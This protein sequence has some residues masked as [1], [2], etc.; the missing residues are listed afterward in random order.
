ME[1]RNLKGRYGRVLSRGGPAK[2]K[3]NVATGFCKPRAKKVRWIPPLKLFRVGLCFLF[4]GIVYP[5]FIHAH[6]PHD[7]VDAFVVSPDYSQ[8]KTLF[9]ASKGSINVFLA[10]HD[11][12]FTWESSRSGMR[13]RLIHAIA[14]DPNWGNSGV[15]YVVGTAGLEKTSDQGQSWQHVY[16]H[17]DLR[18]IALGRDSANSSD[19]IFAS[20]FQ[21]LFRTDLRDQKKSI[22]LPIGQAKILALAVSPNFEQDKTIVVASD[23]SQLFFSRNAGS[24]WEAVAVQAPVHKITFSPQYST[25]RTLWL[26]SHG[27]GILRSKDGGMTIDSMAAKIVGP[28]VNDIAAAPN[29]PDPAHLLAATPQGGVYL[30]RDAGVTWELTGLEIEKNWQ[31]KENHFKTV[32]FSPSYPKDATLFCGTFEGMNI[33]RDGGQNWQECNINPTRMGRRVAISRTFAADHSLFAGGYGQGILIS[34]DGGGTWRNSFRRFKE[35]GAYSIA[36][37]PQY[38]KDSLFLVGVGSGIRR[39]PD[40]GLTWQII[41]LDHKSTGEPKDEFRLGSPIYHIEYSPEFARDHT[42]YAVCLKGDVFRSKDA[43]L[44]W[45]SIAQVSSQWTSRLRLSPN[46]ARDSTMFAGKKFLHRSVDGGQTFEQVLDKWMRDLFVAPDFETSGEVFCAILSSEGVMKS[47]DRGNTWSYSGAGLEGYEPLSMSFSA[48]YKNDGTI[49]LLTLGGGLFRST[50]RG[51]HWERAIPLGTPVDSASCM[52][53]SP[54]FSE[55]GMMLLGVYNGFLLTKDGGGT[56]RH[57]TNSEFYDISRSPWVRRGSDWQ[58][59]YM[60]DCIGWGVAVAERRNQTVAITFQGV[61][62]RLYGFTG[63]DNGKAE[64]KL[65]GKVIQTIDCY[66]DAPEKPR[67]IAEVEGLSNELHT[68]EVRVLGDKNPA[69]SGTKVAID[70]IEVIFRDPSKGLVVL[71]ADQ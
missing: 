51:T 6:H 50:D 28:N 52:A 11:G 7:V 58:N 3:E 63:P 9:L 69:S 55:D 34:S 18:Y 8:D 38:S 61:G 67:T 35:W 19:I 37:S 25:D 21:K 57:I 64:L 47:T 68:L 30:S 20:S 71:G 66:T 2:L 49:H 41:Q 29:Y 24:D 32:S 4:A 10:S 39:S 53:M 23:D 42:I 46:F 60:E 17:Y 26:A 70:A 36:P 45:K 14:F 27:A 65:N 5:A 16:S 1:L 12:G 48:N 44:T 54:N 31:A 13:S 33:S 15:A 40:G 43:G 56:Y 62:F 59:R 22:E